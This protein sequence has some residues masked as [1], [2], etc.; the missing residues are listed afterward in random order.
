M[1]KYHIAQAIYHLIMLLCEGS[2]TPAEI[3]NIFSVPITREK[4]D[5]YGNR[6]FQTQC[7]LRHDKRLRIVRGTLNFTSCISTI[8]HGGSAAASL[9]GAKLHE[10]DPCG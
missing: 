7:A 9:G 1:L 4:D 3:E 6:L 8:L 10:F 2:E 5:C